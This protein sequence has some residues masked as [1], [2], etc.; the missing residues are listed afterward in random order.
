[1]AAAAKGPGTRRQPHFATVT[2]HFRE[3]LACIVDGGV[4][5]D[6]VAYTMAQCVWYA[7]VL[8]AML[9]VKGVLQIA[10]RTIP[11]CSFHDV[12]ASSH[13][14]IRRALLE[15]GF[16]QEDTGPHAHQGISMKPLMSTLM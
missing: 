11:T 5:K 13:V 15:A 16:Q 12:H 6:T 9:H 4:T 7:A 1:M 10:G 3:A 8:T 2:K 14:C